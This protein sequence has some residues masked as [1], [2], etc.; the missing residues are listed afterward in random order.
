MSKNYMNDSQASEIMKYISDTMK[1]PVMGAGGGFAPIGTIN[2][3]DATVA[4]LGWLACDGSVHNISDYPDL[5]T[6]YASVHGASNFYGG[7]GTT[8]FA[9]PDLRG[10]FLRGT[11]TNGHNNQGSGANV[12]VHQDATEMPNIRAGGSDLLFPNTMTE[13]V[14]AT[15]M[16]A[17]NPKNYSTSANKYISFASGTIPISNFKSFTSR[18]TNTSFLIC[19]KATVSGDANAHQ[20]STEEQIVGKWI[21]GSDIYE[22]TFRITA[23]NNTFNIG[24][25]SVYMGCKGMLYTSSGSPFNGLVLPWASL[26]N[27]EACM[28]YQANGG[29]IILNMSNLSPHPTMYSYIT[30][31]YRKT[32]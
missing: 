25:N 27:N 32:Q 11:G 19:V 16:D 29:D 13:Y 22:K 28:P 4:P 5:A 24:L 7:N 21:D 30:I 18:P 6:F 14:P 9:V 23:S 12:G 10:E 1:L 3:F 8:T 31:Q 17:T 20:Y 2:F 26:L 15:N